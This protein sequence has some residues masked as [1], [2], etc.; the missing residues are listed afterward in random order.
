MAATIRKDWHV[1]GKPNPGSE[2]ARR[3]GCVCPVLDNN[4]GRSAPRP[5]DEWVIRLDCPMHSPA[6]VDG[7]QS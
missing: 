2:L 6:T 3:R 7:G 1:S 5:G 4:Y